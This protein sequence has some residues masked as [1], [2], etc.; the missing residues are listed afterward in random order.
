MSYE[1]LISNCFDKTV[2]FYGARL[3]FPF[4]E[5]WDRINGRGRL[6]I[7][8]LHDPDGVPV[9]FLQHSSYGSEAP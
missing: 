8:Q 6:P 2:H 4:I 3:G 7:F 9:T 5:G 1:T